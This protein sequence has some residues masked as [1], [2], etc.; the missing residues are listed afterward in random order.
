[1]S[2]ILTTNTSDNNNMSALNTGINR[3]YDYINFTTDTFEI[4][5]NSEIAVQS[6]KFNK[7]GNVEVNR[8]NNQLYVW[9][10][11]KDA[12][13]VPSDTTSLAVHTTIGDRNVKFQQFNNESLADEIKTAIDRGLCH[14]DLVASSPANTSGTIVAVTRDSDNK[15]TGYSMIMNSGKKAD[16]TNK[17]A[18]MAFVDSL[19]YAVVNGSWNSSTF[20]VT[21]LAGLD[22]E[23]IGS[24][25][26]LSQVSGSMTVDFS[27]AGPL[28]EIGLTRYLNEEANDHTEQN[29]GWFKEDGESFYDYCVKSVWSPAASKYYLRV[30]HAV[31]SGDFPD[32]SPE[33]TCL[34][35]DEISYTHVT[36]LIEVFATPGEYTT[37]NVKRLTFN[38]KNERVTISTTDAAVK[39]PVTHILFQGD[40]ASKTYNLKP[41][42]TNTKY[43]Y[44]KF[45]VA[46][47]DG[48]LEVLEAELSI[49]TGFLY[50]GNM[51]A[52]GVLAGSLALG[53]QYF[54]YFTMATYG[55]SSYAKTLDMRHMF[56]YDIEADTDYT[57]HGLNGDSALFTPG[58][59]ET[60]WG[61]GLVL[62]PQTPTD[63]SPD[64]E[65]GSF[66]PTQGANAGAILGF[67]GTPF[68]ILTNSSTTTSETYLSIN[69]PQ[70]IST[71]SIFVRLNNFLQR[72]INGQ[73]N[74]IS[75]I[76]YHVPR[77]DNGGNEFGGLF[78]EP[79]ERVYI[80]LHNTEK[81]R[82]N[83]FSVSLVNSD[84][85]LAENITGKT[86]VMFHIRKSL[87]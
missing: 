38:I 39:A 22:C 12:D 16:L 5:E 17:R 47:D 30:F 29:F 21:K 9:T 54:D 45:F 10:G 66:W 14:P 35:L 81:L 1:M 65:T 76:V 52:G 36:P 69:V 40:N 32:G 63:D 71:N 60:S 15:F 53:T 80:K 34:F 62:K 18:D 68:L 83:E 72:T 33:Q 70:Q 20:R 55:D 48:Y 3:P 58:V 6:I 84:E 78:F 8:Q 49:P 75:K 50:G 86:I 2:L 41:T 4:A 13:K 24:G 79:S 82:R 28:W 56:N 31:M 7:E 57:Q 46:L 42:S 44:P 64:F 19:K 59:T 43:L 61:V 74:G 87:N 27:N 37:G 77:F 67:Q 73:T 85:T 51:G 11:E 26:P 25:G 23:M